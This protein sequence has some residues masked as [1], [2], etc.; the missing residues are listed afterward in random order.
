MKFLKTK[1]DYI[2]IKE[3]EFWMAIPT[4]LTPEL[5]AEGAAREI[6]RRLQTMRR[7]AGFEVTNHIKLYYQGAPVIQQVL[8]S[9]S[10]YI[11]QE[12]LAT[13]IISETPPAGA[14]AEK[15][16]LLDSEVLFAIQ[17]ESSS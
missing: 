8:N 14:Y 10:D 12:T 1:P 6:V 4:K 16:R 15:H 5:E 9:F 17:K 13:Q 2:S 11:K 3:G 7:S